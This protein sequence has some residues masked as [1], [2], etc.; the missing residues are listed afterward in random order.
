MENGFVRRRAKEAGV[1][2]WRI[3]VALGISE[4]TITRWLRLPLPDCKERAILNAI[5]RLKRE[6]ERDDQCV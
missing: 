5:D 1:P 2:L 4:P 3:A 6:E